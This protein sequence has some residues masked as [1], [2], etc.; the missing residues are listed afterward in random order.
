MNSGSTYTVLMGQ[1]LGSTKGTV[2]EICSK[3]RP[4]VMNE[5]HS[6]QTPMKN[7]CIDGTIESIGLPFLHRPIFDPWIPAWT[8]N[9]QANNTKQ[10]QSRFLD[11]GLVLLFYCFGCLFSLLYVFVLCVCVF[12]QNG[13]MDMKT[14]VRSI[15]W[16][17]Q[18]GM[19]QFQSTVYFCL[20]RKKSIGPLYVVH[21]VR[22]SSVFSQ[23][24]SQRRV[25][26]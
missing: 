1:I 11:R 3:K 23:N 26:R 14:F 7:L 20:L 5:Q 18:K 25:C 22:P 12:C 19:A 24:L 2:L 16:I 9:K 10:N 8:R 15:D 13:L 17:D 4:L 21:N 6:K